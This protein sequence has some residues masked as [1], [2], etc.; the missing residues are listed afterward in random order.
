MSFYSWIHSTNI[1]YASILCQ[2]TMLVV[3]VMVKQR[4]TECGLGTLSDPEKFQ[5]GL[6][7]PTSSIITLKVI[8]SFYSCYE[9]LLM[10]DIKKFLKN[11]KSMPHFPCFLF[12]F[13]EKRHILWEIS[14]L[15][16]YTMI[17]LLLFLHEL[18]NEHC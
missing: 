14:H 5:G 4:L 12:Y 15:C 10:L 17:L 13:G 3:K 16:Y 6:Q 2:I 18:I 11:V 9:Y 1:F 8:C 7:G